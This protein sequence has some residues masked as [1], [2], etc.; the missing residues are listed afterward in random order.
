MEGYFPCMSMHDSHLHTHTHTQSGHTPPRVVFMAP[1]IPR[2]AQT[3]E[4]PEDKKRK[5]KEDEE[6]GR[7][8]REQEEENRVTDDFPRYT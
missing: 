7:R 3:L 8:R 4:K 6:G 1:L 2:G 5:M